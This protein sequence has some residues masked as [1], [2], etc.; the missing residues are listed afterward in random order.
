MQE[1]AEL[2]EWSAR[3]WVVRPPRQRNSAYE[4]E[5]GGKGA[6]SAMGLQMPSCGSPG[7]RP[8]LLALHSA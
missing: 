6:G 7:T 8:T 2:M 1:G 3:R 5:C 4:A